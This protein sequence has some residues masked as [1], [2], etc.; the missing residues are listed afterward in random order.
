MTESHSI[1]LVDSDDD[2][3]RSLAHRLRQRGCHILEADGLEGARQL[4]NR[5]RLD[6]ALV[7]LDSL[8]S[9]GLHVVRA[10]RSQRPSCRIIVLVSPGKT[11]LSIKAMR[12]G[13]FDDQTHPVDVELLLSRIRRALAAKRPAR[14]RAPAAG[15]NDSAAGQVG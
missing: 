3:R 13:A 14:R 12:L 2:T 10:L 1:L 8:E 15:G 11:T 5:R 6:V 7:D 9:A 4:A